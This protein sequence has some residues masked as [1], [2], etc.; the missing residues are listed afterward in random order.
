M[1]EK[2]LIRVAFDLPDPID[3]SEPDKTKKNDTETIPLPLPLSA[4]AGTYNDTGYG[5]SLTL[6]DPS[7]SALNAHAPEYC[8]K[9]IADYA[10]VDA[11]SPPPF[12]KTSTVPA[13]QLLASWPRIWSSHVRLTHKSG[14]K[15]W[16][17]PS[18][19]FL[20]GYGRDTT[21]CDTWNWE[22]EGLG[23][24]IIEFEVVK[25]GLGYPENGNGKVVGMGLRETLDNEGV[26]NRE[27]KWAGKEGA[28]VRDVADTWWDRAV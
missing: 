7:P 13:P 11:V 14:N 6:C 1:L 15:F 2:K 28:T 17:A 26:S 5:G 16:F 3:L 23:E 9:V 25:D 19:L 18:T 24:A 22:G 20:E 4:Y 10:F 27:K 12:S 8:E 21:P